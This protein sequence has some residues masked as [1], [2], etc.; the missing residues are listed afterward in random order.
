MILVTVILTIIMAGP[1]Q[2]RSH[3]QV[4]GVAP[5]LCLRVPPLYI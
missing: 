2:L 3:H 5:S 4:P 1:K